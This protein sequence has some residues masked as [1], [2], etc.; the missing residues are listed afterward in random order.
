MTDFQI[1]EKVKGRFSSG[2]HIVS[3]GGRKTKEQDHWFEGEVVDVEDAES[4]DV[5]EEMIQVR[6]SKK[7]I[8]QQA[9]KDTSDWH[10]ASE[11]MKL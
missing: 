2:P 7:S 6:Y 5:G 4:S 1:G 8:E 3:V 11:L 10:Y 9:F